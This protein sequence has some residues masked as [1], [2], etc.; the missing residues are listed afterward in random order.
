MKN[1]YIAEIKN[2]E[3]LFINKNHVVRAIDDVSFNLRKGEIIGLIGE[4]GSGKSTIGNAIVRLV[5]DYFGDV[6]IDG[7]SVSGKISKKRKKYL[8]KN[9][10][11]IF[12]DPYST[13]NDK[14]NIYSILKESYLTSGEFKSAIANSS[15][16]SPAQPKI[17]FLSRA[18][19]T[20][21]I[22]SQ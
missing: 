11:M 15:K 8:A 22:S 3:K 5:D 13:L 21:W 1:Q 17:W 6:I 2:L 16:S 19:V 18:K 12:Q 14:M 20:D 10:Q 4:S 9:V 7:H